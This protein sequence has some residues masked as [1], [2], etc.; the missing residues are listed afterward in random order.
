MKLVQ[1]FQNRIESLGDEI[2]EEN[3]PEFLSPAVLNALGLAAFNYDFRDDGEDRA[4]FAASLRDLMCVRACKPLCRIVNFL[5]LRAKGFGLPSDWKVF[6]Q[7][8][9]VHVPPWL[10]DP[11]TY[12]PSS[13]LKFL[14]RHVQ[15]SDGIARRLIQSRLLEGDDVDRKDALSRIG[16]RL[17]DHL[18]TSTDIIYLVKANRAEAERWRL[19]DDEL[20]PQLWWVLS[21]IIL[22]T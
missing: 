19:T 13:G 18:R 21:A 8:V 6:C 14:R 10:L 2:Q 17:F 20:A 22:V 16:N 11:M 1:E 4:E 9:M 3:I 12:F 7:G 15:M 5:S